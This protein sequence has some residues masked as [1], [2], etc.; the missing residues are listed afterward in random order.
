MKVSLPDVSVS[1]GEQCLSSS[2][3]ELSLYPRAV[4]LA[5]VFSAEEREARL[6]RRHM[7]ENAVQQEKIKIVTSHKK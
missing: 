5:S 6:A 3:E 4:V 7:R 1:V 2:L